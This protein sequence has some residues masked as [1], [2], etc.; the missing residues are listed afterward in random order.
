L[1][2]AAGLE[3]GEFEERAPLAGADNA[4]PALYG[5]LGLQKMGRRLENW[6]RRRRSRRRGYRPE[7]K[8]GGPGFRFR[9]FI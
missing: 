1:P 5:G 4:R 3:A 6:A 9:V 8:D 7:K 2:F